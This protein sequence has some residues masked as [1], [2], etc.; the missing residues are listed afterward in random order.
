MSNY[1]KSVNCAV[2]DTLTSGDANKIVSGAEIDTEF[3]NISSASTTKIDKVPAATTGNI[4][5]FTATG[6]IEDSSESTTTIIA[7]AASPAGS[8]IAFAGSSAPTGWLECD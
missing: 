4:P 7:A 1:S 6:A 5:Q 2:K 8:V 3:N